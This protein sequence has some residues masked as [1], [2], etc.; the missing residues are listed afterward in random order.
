MS[1]SSLPPAT[2][3]ASRAP[4]PSRARVGE[5]GFVSDAQL[6]AW[7]RVGEAV[8][9]LASLALADG[10]RYVLTD[11]LRVLGR[12]NG[13]TDPYGLTGRVV[14][15]RDVL[16]QGGALFTDALRVGAAIYDVEYGVLATEVRS[17]DESGVNP[18]VR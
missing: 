15:L 9:S 5:D 18:I 14:A 6:D 12:R 16:R 3:T 1:P 7:T 8:R 2:R 4:A 13:E 17:A 10:R 11:A